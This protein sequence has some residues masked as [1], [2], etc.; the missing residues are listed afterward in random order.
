M[1][2]LIGATIFEFQ[3]YNILYNTFYLMICTVGCFIVSNTP[4]SCIHYWYNNLLLI[5]IYKQALIDLM[6]HCTLDAGDRCI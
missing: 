5:Y 3:M 4:I 6:L 1:F 2:K